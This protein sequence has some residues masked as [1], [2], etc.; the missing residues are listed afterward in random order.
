MI[1]VN[2]DNKTG[3]VVSFGK[4]TKPYI[5]ITEKERKQPL[6]D[7][8]SYYAVD[9]GRFCIKHKELTDAEIKAEQQKQE[10]KLTLTDAKKLQLFLDSIPVAQ[11]PSEPKLGYK[12]EP[13]YSG[14]T[15]FAWEL[16]EDVNA[17][18]TNNN[19]WYWVDNMSV[20]LGMFYTNGT[21]K[22]VAIDEGVPTGFDDS[23]YFEVVI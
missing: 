17:V 9:N 12:W 13:M 21:I 7:K 1:K 18:G 3:K 15:G 22:K 2:Y 4:D 10:A 5:E 11:V 20:T 8:Y 6:P 16:V 23:N 14:A 19:P